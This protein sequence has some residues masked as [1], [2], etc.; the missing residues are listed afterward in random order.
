MSNPANIALAR[1]L[2]DSGMAPE[3]T[4][5]IISPD[6]VWDV[7]PGFPSSGIYHGWESVGRDFFGSITPS[8]ESFYAQGEQFY[9][10]DESH[11]FVYGHYHA[12]PKGGQEVQV[13][14][15]HLWTVRDGKLAHMQQA[16]DSYILRQALS[17]AASLGGRPTS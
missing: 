9:A 2:Y 13:R 8:Y 17:A 11:V 6:L 7:T 1:R 12:T 5:E 14:F 16:A 10:D 4:S 15:I 3:V